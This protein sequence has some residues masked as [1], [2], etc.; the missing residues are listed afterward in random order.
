MAPRSFCGPAFLIAALLVGGRWSAAR[1]SSASSDTS[2][3][4]SIVNLLQQPRFWVAVLLAVWVAGQRRMRLPGL[5]GVL[6]LIALQALYAP[7]MQPALYKAAE[8]L[9]LAVCCLA[10]SAVVKNGDFST[11]VRYIEIGLKALT[12]IGVFSL[13]SGAFLRLSVLGGGSNV[14][15]RNAAMVAV[16]SAYK[17]SKGR[18][19]PNIGWF[20]AGALGTVASGSRGALLALVLG[21]LALLPVLARRPVRLL[22][23]SVGLLGLGYV[24]IRFTAAGQRVERVFNERV[25][26]LT[27]QSR[28]AS[29]RTKA[30]ALAVGDW[31][32]SM[33]MGN[34]LGSFGFFHPDYGYP[35]N[36]FTEALAEVGLVGLAL[37]LTSLGG[38]VKQCIANKGAELRALVL[39]PAVAAQFSGDFYDARWV[40]VLLVGLACAAAIPAG[41]QAPSDRV[42]R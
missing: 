15:G 14:F 19:G 40:F 26:R 3:T 7:A 6:V 38:L 33:L 1:L 5:V 10:M 27:F 21:S 16:Y 28:Y 29:N 11:F 13:V 2:P 22:A 9:M 41:D 36:F 34:G 32:K 31:K 17:A 4:N 35:H 25:V 8:M 30:A 23:L 39:V 24:V 42:Q 18:L 37:W 12:V 20:L